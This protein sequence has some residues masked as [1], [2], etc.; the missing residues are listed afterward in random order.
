[1]RFL[2]AALAVVIA[3]M[4]PAF[5]RSSNV[6]VPA[7]TVTAPS[8]DR[9]TPHRV[10]VDGALPG[11]AQTVVV[12]DPAGNE[13]VLQGDASS[14]GHIDWTL[15]PPVGGWPV[16]LYRVALALGG[17]QSTSS[18]FIVEDGQPHL[19]ALPYLPSPTSAIN[20][21]GLGLAPDSSMT[22]TM[23]LTGAQGQ[24]AITVVTD[25]QGAFSLF[26]WPQEFGL[27]F[28]AAGDYRVEDPAA[29]LVT[30]FQLREHPVSATMDVQGTIV[31]GAPAPLS[32][33]NYRSGRM[34]WGVYADA[35]GKV[36][37]EFLLG[38]VDDHGSVT[39]SI[40][41]TTPSSGRYYLATPYDWGET[42]LDVMEPTPTVTPVPPTPTA[43]PTSL[44][45]ATVTPTPTA[46]AKPK[47]PATATAVPK[48][49]AK[50][51]K[52]PRCTRSKHGKRYVVT[53]RRHK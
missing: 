27:P 52:R 19:F 50:R 8:G 53:C 1:M 24:R 13:T 26:V 15:T 36:A 25:A 51:H 32:L 3:S 21:V 11:A 7:L 34:V 47:R 5:A 20:V 39:A 38:P 30:N 14:A 28:F 42:M 37:G 45:T 6:A 33:R 9:M 16:G 41:L 18:T 44:P 48:V 2:V 29:G 40:N 17:G 22:L 31:R 43:S 10:N 23:L 35:A 49:A 4:V 46:T 12:F